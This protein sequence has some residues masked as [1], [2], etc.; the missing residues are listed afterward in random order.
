MWE[1]QL[2]FKWH[3]YWGMYTRRL[4][5]ILGVKQAA[6]CILIYRIACSIFLKLDK[7]CLSSKAFFIELQQF[8]VGLPR[9]E[10]C[11]H[12]KVKSEDLL[13]H[14]DHIPV[15]E[16]LIVIFRYRV[17]TIRGGLTSCEGACQSDLQELS[18]G[19][20]PCGG[21]EGYHWCRLQMSTE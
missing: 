20:V 6:K 19:N 21:W 15:S 9:E 18:K 7:W 14:C 10:L 4:L 3:N 5:K 16:V 13:E 1:C 11:E 2:N 17:N 8:L 12:D